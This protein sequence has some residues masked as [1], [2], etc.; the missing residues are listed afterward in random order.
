MHNVIKNRTPLFLFFLE[1]E[2]QKA[3][4]RVRGS[5]CGQRA[6]AFYERLNN[7]ACRCWHHDP[8]FFF[9]LVGEGGLE[10]ALQE[11][12][13]DFGQHG[14]LELHRYVVQVLQHDRIEF[15]P[16]CKNGVMWTRKQTLAAS[17]TCM[18]CKMGSR[19]RGAGPAA[20]GSSVV[21]LHTRNRQVHCT[22][23]FSATM[24]PMPGMTVSA[25]FGSLASSIWHARRNALSLSPT[26]ILAGTVIL[27][28]FLAAFPCAVVQNGR[29][30]KRRKG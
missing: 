24:C 27:S 9:F 14:L 11:L 20:Q 6:S 13:F 22:L 8:L 29:G 21:E 4:S 19:V 23:F 28:K 2:T 12:R 7:S 26:M 1:E 5:A 25:L 18:H 16:L 17:T 15:R 3:R 10:L 30:E